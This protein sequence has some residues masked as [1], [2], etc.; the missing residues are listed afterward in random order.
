[1]S[2]NVIWRS[3]NEVVFLTS[4]YIFFTFAKEIRRRVSAMFTKL[5]KFYFVL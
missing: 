2:K 3:D 5:S 1:M 4:L